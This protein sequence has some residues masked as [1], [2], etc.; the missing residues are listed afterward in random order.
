[1]T[2][3]TKDGRDHAGNKGDN[4]NS[5]E[6]VAQFDWDNRLTE[7]GF[8][9]VSFVFDLMTGKISEAKC[10]ESSSWLL[11]TIG[12]VSGVDW[13]KVMEWSSPVILKLI[14]THL[15]HALSAA[16]AAAGS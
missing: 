6:V 9:K 8:T 11:K 13:M 15:P 16:A 14:M 3:H 2:T 4:V 10:V 5:V 1:L 7:T 12:A